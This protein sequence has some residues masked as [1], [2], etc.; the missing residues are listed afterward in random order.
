MSSER[1]NKTTA[2]KITL[3]ISLVIVAAVLGLAGYASFSTGEEPPTITVE[4]DLANVR[5]TEFGYYVPITI[6]NDGGLTAQD[7]TVAGELDLGEEMPESAEVTITFLAGGESEQA[8]LV[9]SAHPDEG[10]FSVRPTSY[11]VP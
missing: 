3:A 11:L 2:E 9:F 1:A 7:V 4:A 8:G 5:A 10:E 6:T